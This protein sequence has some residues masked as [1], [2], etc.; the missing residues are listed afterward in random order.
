MSTFFRESHIKEFG[1]TEYKQTVYL[2]F[3]EEKKMRDLFVA[4]F[5]ISRIISVLE[6]FLVWIFVQWAFPM[7]G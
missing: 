5:N 6:A 1:R 4:D 7:I 3:E 2:N